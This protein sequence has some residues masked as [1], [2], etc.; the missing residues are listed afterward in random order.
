MLSAQRHESSKGHATTGPQRDRSAQRASAPSAVNP[1]W[2]RLATGAGAIGGGSDLGTRSQPLQAKLTVSAPNDPYEQEAD[3]VADQ[4]MRLAEPQAQRACAPCTTAIGSCPNCEGDVK[5]QRQVDRTAEPTQMV[6][7]ALGRLDSGHPLEP[8]VRDFFEPRFGRSF[9]DVR[10]HTGEE[11]DS[12]ARGINARAFT[13]GN[14]I[15]F[16][17]GQ[18]APHSEPSRRLLAHELSHVVQQRSSGPRQVRRLGRRE[19]GFAR[20]FS[21]ET[22]AGVGR[23]ISMGPAISCGT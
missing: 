14:R 22:P 23:R 15:V 3:R 11:A 5:V 7:D 10:L 8:A 9:A 2:S 19:R 17:A 4:V 12:A 20:T 18:Y 21:M 13:L 1:I 6:G 16:A